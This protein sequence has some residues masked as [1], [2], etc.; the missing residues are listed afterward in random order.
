MRG[1]YA[2]DVDEE[3]AVF[4][5][6]FALCAEAWDL[7]WKIGLDKALGGFGFRVSV[8]RRCNGQALEEKDEKG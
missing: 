1:F 4:F 7:G 3:K 8:A 2:R 6:F 5:C